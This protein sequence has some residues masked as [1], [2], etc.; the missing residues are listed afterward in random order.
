[1]LPY[2]KYAWKSVCAFLALLATNVAT[3]WVVNGEPLPESGKDWLMFAVTTLGGTWLVF[4]KGNGPKP[5]GRRS[6]RA[7]RP[8][9]K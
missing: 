1:M 4:Q 2:L 8:V 9:A 7:R 6:R 5:V 3:R